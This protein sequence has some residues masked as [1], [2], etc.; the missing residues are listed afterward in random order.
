MS[1][2]SL[3]TGE[4]IGAHPVAAAVE[5]VSALL[6]EAMVGALRSLPDEDL[7]AL[8]EAHERAA[9]KMTAMGLSLVRETDGRDLAAR[10]GAT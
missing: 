9:A 7:L 2:T 8:L 5:A 6:D 3:L 10:A 4:P 1:I